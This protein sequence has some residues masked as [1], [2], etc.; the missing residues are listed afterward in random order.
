L[1]RSAIDFAAH[2]HNV[3]PSISEKCLK[4]HKSRDQL[5]AAKLR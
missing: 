5:G 2:I 3:N 1:R 4:C